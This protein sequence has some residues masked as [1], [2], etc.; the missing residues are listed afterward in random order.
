MEKW[1]PVVLSAQFYLNKSP[2]TSTL[3][4]PIWLQLVYTYSYTWFMKPLSWRDIFQNLLLL[5]LVLGS[6]L[7]FGVRGGRI[8][9][10]GVSL[11]G[12]P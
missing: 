4:P 2:N 3:N 1:I 5:R 7:G 10:R 6:G 8:H 9:G 11:N 12:R